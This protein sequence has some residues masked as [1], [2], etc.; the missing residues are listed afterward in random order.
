PASLHPGRTLKAR[1]ALAFGVIAT[2]LSMLLSAIVGH[3]AERQ[4]A[5]QGGA[6]LA[7]LAQQTA[8][9]LDRQMFERCKDVQTVAAFPSFGNPWTPPEVQRALLDRPDRRERRGAGLDGR[10]PGGPGRLDAE[11]VRPG[12]RGAVGRRRPRRGPARQPPAEPDRRAAAIRRHRGAG[13]RA[14]G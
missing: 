4:V 2:M 1:L 10:H 6:A 7:Q 5:D 14:G 13:L 3:M 9:K 12:T 11:L 8:D